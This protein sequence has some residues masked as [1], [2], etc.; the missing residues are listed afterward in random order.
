[1]NPDSDLPAAPGSFHFKRHAEWDKPHHHH[2]QFQ[3]RGCRHSRNGLSFRVALLVA[4]RRDIGDEMNALLTEAGFAIVDV[5][6]ATARRIETI[7]A[8]RGKGVHP[9]GLNFGDC[10]AYDVARQYGR[11]LLYVGDDFSRTDITGVI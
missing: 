10:F 9:A 5:T 2:L 3:K 11:P 8:Q 4:G 7:Y 1:L 6:E